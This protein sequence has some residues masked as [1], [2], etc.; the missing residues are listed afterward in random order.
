MQHS[1]WLRPFLLV[2]LLLNVG[3]GVVIQALHFLD[4][5][6]ALTLSGVAYLS[7]FQVSGW[8]VLIV[9]LAIYLYQKK[10]KPVFYSLLVLYG[11]LTWNVIRVVFFPPTYEEIMAGGNGTVGGRLYLL[12]VL[13]HVATILF[14]NARENRWLLYYAFATG[15]VSLLLGNLSVFGMESLAIFL[16]FA[17]ELI[18][19]VFVFLI[20]D[21]MQN[22]AGQVSASEILDAD[23]Q[24]GQDRHEE[25]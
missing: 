10:Y 15:V 2:L 11:V 23:I 3:I 12:L 25:I 16:V 1:L 7:Y 20:R 6:A 24:R 17:T 8:A 22:K 14:S 18:P 5:L 21:L 4:P 9:S 13:I 19:L